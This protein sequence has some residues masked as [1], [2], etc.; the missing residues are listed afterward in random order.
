M[1]DI[2]VD[3]QGHITVLTLNRPDRMNALSKSMIA[4]LADAVAVFNADP[5]QYVA[6]LTGAGDKSFCAGADLKAMAAELGAGQ[7]LP[8]V[9]EPDIA[10]VGASEKPVIAALNGF[11]VAGGL[12]LALCCDIRI[13]VEESW[14]AAFEVAHGIMAGVAVSI[15]PRLLPFGAAMELMLTGERMTAADAYR[16]GLVQKLT[17]REDLMAEAVAKAESIARNSQPA[18]RGTKQV[19]RF[20]RDAMLAEQQRYY[21]AVA[22]RVFLSGDMHEGPRAFAEKRK[23]RFNN[24]WPDPMKGA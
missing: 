18:V 8:M 16:L 9:Y 5:D 11:A 21:E 23:P 22:H 17:R 6:I 4:E 24:R 20:W 14:F 10:G 7:A 2:L 13:A 1:A 12:E 15:L 3:R 19:L